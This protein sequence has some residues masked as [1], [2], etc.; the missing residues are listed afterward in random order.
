MEDGLVLH[1]S[2]FNFEE[3]HRRCVLPEMHQCELVVKGFIVQILE[4]YAPHIVNT[5]NSNELE[6]ASFHG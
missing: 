6:K 4:F 3:G 1:I 5:E 2:E